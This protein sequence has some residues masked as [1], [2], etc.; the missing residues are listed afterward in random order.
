M[1]LL[2][3]IAQQ[4]N[5]SI[6]TKQQALDAVAPA[7]AHAAEAMTR[8]LLAERKILACG[9]GG[10]A[11]DAQHFSSELLN[12]F[13]MERPGLPALALTTDS[14]T[15]T[16]IANDYRFE[17]VFAKQ[18]RA[19]GQPGDVL[20]AISTSGNSANVVQATHAAHDRDM[21][22]VALTGREGGELADLLINQDVEIRVPALSTARIQEVHIL[23]IHCLCDL[24][25]QQLLG[26]EA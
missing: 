22:V 13:E 23:V 2:A 1:D 12:R 5:D 9:N 19:L 6:Q 3:R 21:R 15:L 14:S 4:F 7:I 8:A 26:Q 20:L 11:A 10:S 16:S 24:I 25:D 18:V 17:E